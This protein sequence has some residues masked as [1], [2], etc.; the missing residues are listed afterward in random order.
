VGS[1]LFEKGIKK[2]LVKHLNFHKILDPSQHG[3]L[4]KHSTCS[5]LIEAMSDWTRNIDRKTGTLVAYVDF[6][7]AF[8]K[9]S[10]PKLLY[11]LNHIGISGKL[12]D[13]ISSFLY[14][15]TQRVRVKDAL[16]DI[17]PLISGVPQ[18]SVLGP[19]LFLIYINDVVV[20]QPVETVSKL[21]ADDLK[22]YNEISDIS[23]PKPFLDTLSHINEWSILWQLPVAAKKC[24]IMFISNKN[25]SRN[26]PRLFNIG[27]ALLGETDKIEDLG[28]L[29]TS[30]LNFHQHIQSMCSK[31]RSQIF[32]L[33]KRFLCKDT[34]YLI[35]AYKTYI[36]P[37]LNYCSPV[38]SPSAAGDILL[39]ERVQKF[40]TKNLFGCE[41]LSYKERLCKTGLKSLELIR[42][43][44]DL[45]LCYKILHNL[46]IID[47]THLFDL[48]PYY[49]PRSHGLIL[50]APRARTDLA[51][52]S[53][54]YRV[55]NAWNKLSANTVWAP[56][57]AAFKSYLL[58]ED[59]SDS[60]TLDVDTFS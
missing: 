9:V 60:L 58:S 1:K 51:L 56:S 4:E 39:I 38:W 16:S 25:S 26:E 37:I 19:I 5:N 18:G 6:Q 53:F 27:T 43:Q 50:K 13:C 24:Q 32:L 2:E 11:K 57:L 46:V 21:Y 45:I 34:K 29:F 14:G 59:L 10:F 54:N 36:L 42:L 33:R 44:A 23:N 12:L 8:D 47:N 3:F 22:C 17:V 30:S 35:L 31:A 49:G 40:F 48:D 20:N 41:G 55:C 52:H 15:R 28:L 7:K